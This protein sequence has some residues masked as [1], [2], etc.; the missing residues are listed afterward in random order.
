MVYKYDTSGAPA[1]NFDLAT[2]NS[3][4]TGITTD[5][6]KI[7]VVNKGDVGPQEEDDDDDDEDHEKGV[8]RRVV[9]EYNIDG[10][11]MSALPIDLIAPT[12]ETLYNY[13]TNRDN[14]P[15]LFIKKSKKG[16]TETDVEKF[17]PWRTV[18]LAKNLVI[19][20]DV[21]LTVFS[22][23]KDFEDGKEGKVDIF[24]R[25]R[26]PTGA[27]TEL[28]R[29]TI[30]DDNWQRGSD[31]FIRQ[32]V[33]MPS[34]DHTIPLGNELEVRFT[35][36]KSGGHDMWFAY[37]TET[38]PALL[39]ITNEFR[40]GGTPLLFLH[41]NPTPPTGDTLSPGQFFKL[42]GGNSD[43]AGLTLGP[44][45]VP[46]S[47]FLV[48]DKSDDKVYRYELSGALTGSFALVSANNDAEGITTDGSS[49][50]VVDKGDK[51][52]YEYDLLS[53][54]SLGSFNLT[55][56]N[57][58]PKGIT[59]DGITIWVV[60]KED[61][62][63][64]KYDI[65]GASIGSFALVSDN[66][67]ADGIATDGISAWVVDK[68][69][70][71]VYRYNLS[72]TSEGSFAM[73]HPDEKGSG[74]TTDGTNIW[75]IDKENDA[76]RE[77]TTEGVLRESSWLP[78]DLTVPTATTR[79]NYDTDRDNDAGLLIR[80]SKNGLLET[81]PRKFQAW[82]TTPLSEDLSIDEDSVV[83]FWSA[84]KNLVMFPL[85]HVLIC[86]RLESIRERLVLWTSIA[87][88]TLTEIFP[89]TMPA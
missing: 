54:A 14:D 70:K 10:S 33:V 66:G 45:S 88:E 64:Y 3:D 62:V 25:D 76:I 67:D 23:I 46:E 63:V 73:T 68:K 6:T 2:N 18:P 80:K 74:I 89:L 31:T 28:A 51:V 40:I 8:K 60:D 17:Q 36:R 4:A 41:N 44:A 55:N 20:G 78:M 72:G 58:D 79:F 34:V 83:D 61:K 24:L 32:T 71:R 84:I 26:D 30:T 12:T 82:R 1:G 9:Y 53:G 11:V 21:Y 29:T 42:S 47:R 7:W 35:A 69:D 5:G 16:L 85:T 39:N 56:A 81:D 50:W 59:S 75:I 77:Y 43:P 15:G 22:A 49:I 86:A 38:Y 87:R 27:Y 37:D 57:G 19:L 65:T 13:D 52:V 48:V